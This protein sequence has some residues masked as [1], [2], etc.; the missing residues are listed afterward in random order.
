LLLAGLK[1]LLLRDQVGR[2]GRVAAC[3]FGFAVLD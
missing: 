2:E 1:M 3:S